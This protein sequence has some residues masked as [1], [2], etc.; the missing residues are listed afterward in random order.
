VHADTALPVLAEI[1]TLSVGVVAMS[2]EFNVCGLTIVLDL[3]VVLDSLSCRQ[4]MRI[5]LHQSCAGV[6]F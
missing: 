4:S 2:E 6:P 5:G 3:L 1:Y